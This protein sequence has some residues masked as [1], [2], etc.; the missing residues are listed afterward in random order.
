M[1][2]TEVTWVFGA[3][4]LEEAERSRSEAFLYPELAGGQMAYFPDPRSRANSH[5]G[6][7]IRPD[8]DGRF[9]P[10]IPRQALHPQ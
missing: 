1:F 6:T 9:D 8:D 3:G 5:R 2:R 7:R 10:Q 4:K